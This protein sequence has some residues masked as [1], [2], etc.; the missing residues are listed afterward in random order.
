MEPR[1]PYTPH[2]G[3]DRGITKFVVFAGNLR[4]FYDWQLEYKVRGEE[5]LF[6]ATPTTLVGR[7][8]PKDTAYV[9]LGSFYGREDAQ[10]ALRLAR[11]NNPEANFLT[12]PYPHP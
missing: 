10:E 3:I 9:I 2:H 5:A 12:I 1:T 6:V 4:E 8:F 7:K 11:E